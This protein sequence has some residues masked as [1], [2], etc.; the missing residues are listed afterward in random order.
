M[1]DLVTSARAVERK[2][3]VIAARHFPATRA[4]VGPKQRRTQ[5]DRS[6][7]ELIILSV[8]S[9]KDQAIFMKV[10]KDGT[11]IRSGGGG[12]PG[13]QTAAIAEVADPS[14]FEQ[15][16]REVPEEAVRES[17]FL[18]AENATDEENL[19]EFS[20]EFYGNSQN[21]EHN[22]RADWKES[23]R[24]SL[25]IDPSQPV[26]SPLLSYLDGLVTRAASL[27]NSW[28]FDAMIEAGLHMK[29]DQLPAQTIISLPA[30]EEEVRTDLGNY[31]QQIRISPQGWELGE[32]AAGKIYSNEKGERFT[33]SFEEHADR[34]HYQFTPLP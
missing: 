20:A 2:A 14:V 15:L 10:Y 1:A 25:S 22:E 18:R 3:A 8:K 23:T 32:F 19:L 12:F 7:I 29:S 28:Y 4:A 24:I 13:V 17:M 33:L 26:S 27:T 9:R 16:F 31:L 21:D 30:D 34:I 6:I 11:L 5:M